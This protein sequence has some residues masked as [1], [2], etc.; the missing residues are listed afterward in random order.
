MTTQPRTKLVL[1][2]G[3]HKTG[4]TSLQDALATGRIQL[5]GRKLCYPSHLAH[6]YL[7]RQF[8]AHLDGAPIKSRPGMPDLADLAQMLR[9]GE[10]DYMVLSAE[11]FEYFPP[12]K[13][14]QAL[15]ETLLP[16]AAG[17][18]VICYV[19]P[20]AGRTLSSFCEQLKLGHFDGTLE[21]FH[22]QN[23]KPA[24]FSY[25]KRLGQW[26]R[27]FGKDLTVRIMDRTTLHRGSVVADFVQTAFGSDAA[28]ARLQDSETANSSLC[29][30]ELAMMKV[31]F[32]QLSDAN[33]ALTHAMGW[34]M[35][36]HLAEEAPVSTRTKP[37]I[38]RSL[39]ERLWR[40]HRQDAKEMDTRYCR[41]NAI[42]LPALEKTV[43]QAVPEAQ[44]FRPEDHFPAE[45]LRMLRAMARMI[46]GLMK[47][48]QTRWPLF[49]H[50]QRVQALHGG[51]MPAPLS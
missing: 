3:H 39:A 46:D 33:R 41:D 38:H 17:L 10:H 19:R 48:G 40:D 47:N 37:A 8:S 23:L 22:R 35:A 25:A 28:Q 7:P 36:R 45:T 50:Q 42:F 21:D 5:V 32:G 13:A 4:S 14:Y 29:V 44:S 43:E 31:L 30:E 16:N 18:S 26:Q 34:D 20:H 11:D 2:I 6:N 15:K 49:L 51:T 9:Q 27:Q 24:R 12:A 1:H